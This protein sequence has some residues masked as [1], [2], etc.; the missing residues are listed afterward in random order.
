MSDAGT[1]VGGAAQAAGAVASANIA[2]AASRHAVDVANEQYQQT[3]TD[4][5]PYN[6]AGQSALG[7]LTSLARSG[8]NGGGTNYLSWAEQSQPGQMTQAQLEATPGYQ[9]NLSQGLRSAQ[10]AAAARGLGVSGAALK[11]AATFATGL[12]DSTYQ[13]QFNNAQTRF[14]NLLSMNSAQ[15]GNL[16]NQYNRLSNVATMGE[17]A[18]AKTGAIGANLANTAASATQAAGTA[19]AAGLMG[20]GNAISGSVNNY[21]GNKALQKYTGNTS[22]YE[23]TPINY[24]DSGFSDGG[25]W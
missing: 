17:D 3:R 5:Q 12:A 8:P 19:S 4:L 25:G 14:S 13:N 10:N 1:A 24:N 20:A 7:D 21:L 18:G 15:Q 16:T 22:G 11:G 9:F 23:N 6:E 2:A